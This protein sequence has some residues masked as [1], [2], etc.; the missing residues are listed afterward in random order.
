MD[1]GSKAPTG[2]WGKELRRDANTPRGSRRC[3]QKQKL[4][5]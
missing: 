2:L 4:H 3:H 1:P 5:I